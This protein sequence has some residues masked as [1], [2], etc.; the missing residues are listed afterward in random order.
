MHLSQSAMSWFRH[1][2]FL[3]YVGALAAAQPSGGP[4]GPIDQRYEIPTSARVYF[5][6][7]EGKAESAGTSLDQPTTLESA[8]D[9]VVTGDAII[10][11]GGVYRT[12][13]LTLNQG[14]TMQPYADERPILKGTR[15]ATKWEALRNNVWRTSA[16]PLFPAAPLG[17]WQRNR[18]GMRTPLHRFNNDMVFVDGEMLRSEGWEGALDAHSFYVDYDAGAVYIGVDRTNTLV[19]ITAHGRPRALTSRRVQD[20]DDGNKGPPLGCLTFSQSPYRAVELEGKRRSPSAADPTDRPVGL[21]DPS[22]FGKE[23]VGTT[24][25]TVT[26]TFCSRV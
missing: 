20:K 22:T 21:S 3:M 12:G 9:R 7:P 4:Y 16:K 19:E 15:V 2:F 5:V 26:V 11:R 25:E 6:A 17:W 13:G 10:L 1:S 8:I 23:V 24:I 14:V 18:E